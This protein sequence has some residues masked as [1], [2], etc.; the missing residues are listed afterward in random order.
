MMQTMR[1]K[2]ADLKFQPVRHD[3][4]TFLEK[5][6]RRRGFNEAY[7]ALDI[8]YAIAHEMLAARTRSGLTQETAATLN[9][10]T[11]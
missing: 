6:S 2:M 11:R 9:D 1:F 3:C 10:R 7:E 5:A 8:A 4:K